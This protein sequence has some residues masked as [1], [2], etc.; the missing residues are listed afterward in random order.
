MSWKKGEP[1]RSGTAE[2]GKRNGAAQLGEPLAPNP[3][4]PWEERRAGAGGEDGI[5][6]GPGHARYA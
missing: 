1:G 4:N 6:A 2:G 5:P 3:E